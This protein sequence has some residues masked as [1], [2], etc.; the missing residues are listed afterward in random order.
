[1]DDYYL[2]IKSSDSSP[3][4]KPLKEKIIGR[5]KKSPTDTYFDVEI[6]RKQVQRNISKIK[7]LI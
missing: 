7:S 5:K 1:M 4:K 2:T 6:I 3:K